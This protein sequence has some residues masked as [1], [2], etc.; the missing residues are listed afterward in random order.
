MQPSWLGRQNLT[1]KTGKNM[2]FNKV[3]M[4][5]SLTLFCLILFPLSATA[6][7]VSGPLVETN[8][9]ESNL[10]NVV[11]LDVRKKAK[12]DTQRIPGATLVPW[13]KL[14]AKKKENGVDL[15][16]M[17]PE[18]SA[19][20]ELMQSVGVNN[21]SMIVITSESTDE[22]NT[23]FGTRLYWQLKYFGHDNVSLLNGGNAKWF[24]EKR[25]SSNKNTHHD[26]GTFKVSKVNKDILATTEDVEKAVN[27]KNTTLI[28]ARSEDMYLGLFY[29]KKYVYGAGH[30]P[31]AKSA[32]GDMFLKHGNVKKFHTPEKIKT[33]LIAKGIDPESKS[34]AYCNSGHL[35]SGIWFIEHEILGNKN[36]TLYDGSMHAW[37]K[38]S[39]RLIV[40]MK[41]E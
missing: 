6:L 16:K 30:I 32:D 19:F 39:D 28:D 24:K 33:A 20:E 36:A 31:G 26:K 3:A 14:R 41:V 22:N 40:S 21:D 27:D 10:Q 23:F 34:I 11:V 38:A 9:L 4:K 25:A 35:A 1:H 7:D 29:K 2:N 13:K 37:T 18:K 17:L 8:W 15:I 5:I 12:Q